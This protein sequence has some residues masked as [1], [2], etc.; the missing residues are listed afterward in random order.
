MALR[1]KMS[2]WF[3][4]KTKAKVLKYEGYPL[5]IP[6]VQT[7]LAII[8]LGV[9]LGLTPGAAGHPVIIMAAII[10]LGRIMWCVY[11]IIQTRMVKPPSVRSSI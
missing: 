5:W 2:V 1:R 3:G 7:P 11:R 6:A 9:G 10:W 4:Q 8:A